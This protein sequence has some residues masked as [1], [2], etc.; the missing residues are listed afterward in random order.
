[1][2]LTSFCRDGEESYGLV[3]DTGLHVVG[4]SWQQ[5]FPSL[6]DVLRAEAVAEVFR[7]TDAA[8]A[9]D[10]VA[11]LPPIP[12]PGR[13]LCVGMNYMAHIREMGRKPPQYP[14]VFVRFPDSLV[15]HAANLVI[16]RVSDR[17]DFEGELAVV[18]GRP[19]RHVT[20]DTA[21]N[22]VAGYSCFMDGTL[23]DFQRH[24]SQFT[25]GKNFTASGAM[26][27]C[28]VTR[29]EIPDPTVLK[30]ETRVNGEIMQT[31]DLA[32][33]CIDIPT[34]IAYLSQIFELQPGDVIATGTSAGVGAAR[35]PQRWLKAG[36]QVTVAIDGV[37][38]LENI[39]TDEL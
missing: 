34:I 21:L 39:V 30:L 15:G 23:R 8:I 35:D 20:R 19:C 3:T 5:Q 32:D 16:P 9:L 26:G 31:A 28:L 38:S 27:P 18:M 2:R 22:Y 11:Y 4:A 25:P 12:K 37:G 7:H 10:Q 6:A 24:T 17:Y 33:L 36:D 14:A 1:M 29:D 13:I